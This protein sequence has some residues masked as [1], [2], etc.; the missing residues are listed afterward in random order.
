MPPGRDDHP[1]YCECND[2]DCDRFP[3]RVY[4]EG[5]EAGYAAGH[6]AG[7]AT[8]YAEGYT[9]GHADATAEA[10]PG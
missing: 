4:R 10:K 1:H 3:C 7:H 5:Y 8:G 9:E 2:P 6:A